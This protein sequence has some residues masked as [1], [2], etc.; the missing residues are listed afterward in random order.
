M[1]GASRLVGQPGVLFHGDVLCTWCKRCVEMV[2]LAR[3]HGRC[4]YARRGGCILI[5]FDKESGDKEGWYQIKIL[6]SYY[7]ELV[8]N[9]WSSC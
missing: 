8:R 3:L 1:G 7:A 9:T 5:P 4:M 2:E 6:A